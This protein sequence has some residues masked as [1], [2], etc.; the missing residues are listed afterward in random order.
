[1]HHIA[2]LE[3]GSSWDG[4]V[5]MSFGRCESLL[6][7]FSLKEITK[8]NLYGSLQKAIKSTDKPK[9]L[10]VDDETAKLLNTVLGPSAFAELS[11]R[12]TE[13]LIRR[14]AADEAKGAVYFITPTK[15]NVE[16][17]LGH[18]TPTQLFHEGYVI[19]SRQT[20]REIFGLVRPSPAKRSLKGWSDLDLDFR[21]ME[22]RVFSLELER[23]MQRLYDPSS[24]QDL[25]NTLDQIVAKLMSLFMTLQH[26]P[27]IKF[28]DPLGKRM[29][30][31][32]HL[33]H[34]LML[35]RPELENAKSMWT[36]GS[37]SCEFL[38]LDRNFDLNTPFLHTLA[39][40]A[41]CYDFFPVKDGTLTMPKL[42]KDG[43]PGQLEV[44][45][46][47][48]DPIFLQL[49]H[50]HLAEAI[51]NI[52][53]QFNESPAVIAQRGKGNLSLEDMRKAILHFEEGK[54]VVEHLQLTDALSSKF[55]E[56]K[57]EPVVD[58]ELTLATGENHRGEKITPKALKEL[59]AIISDQSI[60]QIDR[61]RLA[62][63]A[64]MRFPYEEV[65][66]IAEEVFGPKSSFYLDGLKHIMHS[67]T[68][69]ND[70]KEPAHRYSFQGWSSSGKGYQGNADY[71]DIFIPAIDRIVTDL[72]LDEL[73]PSIV[74]VDEQE[75]RQ[76]I[77]VQGAFGSGC[78]PQFTL[79]KPSWAA[80]KP[81]NSDD[82]E[83][84]Y[85]KN[86][87]RI[88][89]FVLGGVS[90]AEVW[91]VHQL[92]KKLK[93]DIV[94]GGTEM[95]I[96]TEFLQHVTDLG[97]NC[98]IKRPL[99]LNPIVDL[100]AENLAKRQSLNKPLQSVSPATEP[101]TASPAAP[102][103]PRAV[104][105]VQPRP[106]PPP[107]PVQTSVAQPIVSPVAPPVVSPRPVPS[108][109]PV[110]Q[111]VLS[112]AVP[113]ATSFV[114]ASIAPVAAQAAP[115]LP[116]RSAVPEPV[117]PPPVLSQQASVPAVSTGQ[118]TA[119][120]ISK[121]LPDP[122]LAKAAAETSSNRATPELELG[123]IDTRQAARS[124]AQRSSTSG[125]NT[126]SKGEKYVQMPRPNPPEMPP[127]SFSF[128]P[129]VLSP[130][131]DAPPPEIKKQEN[132]YKQ[133][134]LPAAEPKQ[135]STPLQQFMDDVSKPQMTVEPYISPFQ[136]P[137]QK[138][139]DNR[140][141]MPPQQPVLTHNASQEKKN[142]RFTASD[143]RSFAKLSLSEESADSKESDRRSYSPQMSSV[144]PKQP[145]RASPKSANLE[146][147]QP[148]AA[149]PVSTSFGTVG[150]DQGSHSSQERP[151]SSVP[152]S[153]GQ[154]P[155]QGYY[156]APSPQPMPPMQSIP[157][158]NIPTG[159]FRPSAEV[160]QQVEALKQYKKYEVQQKVLENRMQQPPT[161]GVRP[162]GYAA[163]PT[164]QNYAP[165]QQAYVPPQP[166][167]PPPQQAVRVQYPQQPRPQQY[168]PQQ[169]PPKQYPQPYQQAYPQ[170]PAQ[171]QQPPVDQ[172]IKVP[173]GVPSAQY[174]P[175]YPQQPGQ[176]QY[177]TTSYEPYQQPQPLQQKPGYQAP[178]RPQ[179]RPVYQQ[180]PQ[181]QF[182][183][184][185]YRQQRP[186]PQQV[187]YDPNQY[188]NS[189]YLNQPGQRPPAG[190]PP[191]YQTRPG[192]PR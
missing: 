149:R 187:P 11:F 80:N 131:V 170:R 10:V 138:Y 9:I 107:V 111:P 161:V 88:I 101:R 36:S 157:E 47:E 140:A 18:F 128:Q 102:V 67:A 188:N 72:A 136:Q 113:T 185:A 7:M 159:G 5:R 16:M 63:L 73:D 6:L 71:K 77:A 8:Q 3:S 134:S 124:K 127:P 64:L 179:P 184:Q 87:P 91:A 125:S 75:Q 103:Q 92:C 1:M 51:E 96:P 20:P 186:P 114:A 129:L 93:R 69:G 122:S 34:K 126:S 105:P 154:R 183:G 28:W 177:V 45:L 155:V 55:A 35:A 153:F 99:L 181:N 30:V 15:E 109:T 50:L 76:S 174:R 147:Q 58:L 119:M 62:A 25:D 54:S 94:I 89:I 97:Y 110:A 139:V 23:T 14:P 46:V 41:A 190:Y 52:N 82:D 79:F 104:S 2:Q 37:H 70:S 81:G 143:M 142:K 38:I 160:Q 42:E 144:D 39:Y 43:V 176:P 146:L 56:A 95:C 123:N 40:E 66:K 106:A 171:Y 121:P 32:S 59:K 78:V 24:M 86:G 68:N 74:A 132:V 130:T 65:Q 191:N 162:G 165:Q 48:S 112:A 100:S 135:T 4:G 118:D 44:R 180:A 192:N 169:Y 172:F 84:D 26:I 163:Y 115:Q 12:R 22:S 120:D 83:A 49:R 98:S 145:L 19:A 33:A 53:R 141:S 148:V 116:T 152:S 175:A 85:L 189:P 158:A 29:N 108:A 117:R 173:Q 164:P 150:S 133:A 167:V 13:K 31:A 27:K 61:E 17:I 168:P 60:S 57:L 166:Y 90:H 21:A 156:A 178:A 137:D 151:T 182:P